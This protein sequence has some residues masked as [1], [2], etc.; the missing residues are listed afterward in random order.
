M[1]TTEQLL[2]RP[3]RASSIALSAR[4]AQLEPA[5]DL[6]GGARNRLGMR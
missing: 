3:I 4:I 2:G 6:S 1:P 5:D